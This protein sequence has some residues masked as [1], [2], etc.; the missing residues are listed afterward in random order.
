VGK[1]HISYVKGFIARVAQPNSHPVMDKQVSSA[2]GGNIL[3]EMP[4]MGRVTV[5]CNLLWC[6]YII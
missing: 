3:L 5:Y 6:N 2:M 4:T 1:P